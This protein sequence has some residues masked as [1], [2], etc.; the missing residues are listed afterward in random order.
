[1]QPIQILF[2][3]LIHSRH[4]L[5]LGQDGFLIN[6]FKIAEKSLLTFHR[7]AISKF[8]KNGGQLGAGLKQARDRPG[9]QPGVG[10]S[11]DGK[12]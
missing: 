8:F 3:D 4:Y 1:M 9:G 12:N 7:Q 5:E 2:C 11:R 6:A 10:L